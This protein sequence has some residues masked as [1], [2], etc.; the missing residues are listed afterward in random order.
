MRVSGWK[1]GLKLCLTILSFL[2]GFCGDSGC[3]LNTYVVEWAVSKTEFLLDN[4]AFFFPKINKNIPN[5]ADFMICFQWSSNGKLVR[6]VISESQ[7][8]LLGHWNYSLDSTLHQLFAQIGTGSQ[9]NGP[10]A[11]LHLLSSA[12]GV[13]HLSWDSSGIKILSLW[14]RPRGMLILIGRK[15][16]LDCDIRINKGQSLSLQCKWSHCPW[17]F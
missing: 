8:Q 15:K 12:F 1:P 13:Y 11:F 4:G 5:E 14:K 16:A 9:A 17:L 10:E 3:S 7:K 2:H 6:S